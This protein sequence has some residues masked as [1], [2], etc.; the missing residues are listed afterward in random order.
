MKERIKNYRYSQ[1]FKDAVL[2]EVRNGKLSIVQISRIYNLSF[3]T[4]YKWM[5]ENG[6]D[7][8]EK[9]TVYV[10]LKDHKGSLEKIKKLEDKIQS[11][12]AALSDK[13]LENCALEATVNV[14]KKKYGLDLKKKKDTPASRN[15]EK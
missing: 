13:I 7:T 3:V 6:I 14:A 5:R 8:P 11:L 9:E 4:V 1:H 2:K 10:D 15:A 12:Q